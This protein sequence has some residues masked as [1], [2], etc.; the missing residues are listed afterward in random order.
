MSAKTLIAAISESVESHLSSR[1]ERGRDGFYSGQVDI[2][3]GLRRTPRTVIPLANDSR[4]RTNLGVLYEMSVHL[5][6]KCRID[7]VETTWHWA[8]AR[9]TLHFGQAF[10]LLERPY[11]TPPRWF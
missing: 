2:T 1:T 7:R 9:V 11:T 10:A 4:S 6:T 5:P 8:D 3:S